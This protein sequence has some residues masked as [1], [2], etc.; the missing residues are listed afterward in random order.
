MLIS[1]A[2]IKPCQEFRI[3]VTNIYRV[4]H[5]GWSREAISINFYGPMGIFSYYPAVIITKCAIFTICRLGEPGG[6][7]AGIVLARYYVMVGSIKRTKGT[8]LVYVMRKV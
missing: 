6:K 2:V 1:E 3:R 4:G 8:Y 5:L 7:Q